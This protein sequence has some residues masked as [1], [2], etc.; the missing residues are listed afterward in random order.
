MTLSNIHLHPIP[1]PLIHLLARLLDLLQHSLV[2][3]LGPG[4]DVGGLAFEGDGVGFYPYGKRGGGVSG[5]GEERGVGRETWG[6]EGRREGRGEERG[7]ERVA[8]TEK[9]DVP[10]IFFNTRSTAPEQPPQLMLMLN[11]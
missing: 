2:R 6:A 9:G 7:G 1:L 8:G 11:L 4:R 3:D 5:V 10:S